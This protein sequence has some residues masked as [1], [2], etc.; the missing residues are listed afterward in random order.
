MLAYIRT[1]D[2]FVT[3]MH[4]LAPTADGLLHRV[5]FFNPGSNY[6]QVS[7][8]LLQNRGA[9]DANATIKGI[10]DAGQSPGTT[11]QVR[12]PAGKAVSL[13]SETLEEGGDGFDGALGDGK[14]KW[15][16]R[17]T[18]DQP[19]PGAEPAN[20]SDRTPHQPVHRSGV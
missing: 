5:A 10:D 15:R 11:V 1:K 6:R 2:G 4:D 12:V 3:S 20:E 14:G 18:S 8:L 13:G 17:V 19:I 16:L 9:T 7:H